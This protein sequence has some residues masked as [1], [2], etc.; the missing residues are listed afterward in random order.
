MQAG[1]AYLLSAQKAEILESVAFA[2]YQLGVAHYELN[3][4]ETAQSH[5][6]ANLNLRFHAHEISYHSS[7]QVLAL[8]YLK[9]KQID[10]LQKLIWA[11]QELEGQTKSH[12][13]IDGIHSFQAR[14][15][16][17]QGDYDTADRLSMAAYN[18]SPL[19]PMLLF[20]IP[21]LT[22]AKVLVALSTPQSVAE[23]LELLDELL[24]QAQIT[25]YVWREIGILGLQALALKAQGDSEAALSRLEQAVTLAQPGKL[26][27]TFVDLGP[28]LAGLL[29]QLTERGVTRPYLGQLLKAFDAEVKASPQSL[30]AEI[31]KPLTERETEILMLLAER[32]TNNEIAQRL[33]ISPKT[34]KRHAS[35]IYQKLGVSNRRQAATKAQELGL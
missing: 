6:E 5:L 24:V 21:A 32:L 11:M 4:L 1:Q 25:H 17:Y 23:A 18:G 3:E 8:V 7:L 9:Q 15:T 2:H 29:R 19:G 31:I 12:L 16:L 22:R 14:L 28:A 30:N 34:V 35:N 33:V 10:K 26:L 13:L 20:E 27:R